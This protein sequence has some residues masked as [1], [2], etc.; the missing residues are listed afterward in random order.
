MSF[1]ELHIGCAKSLT[2]VGFKYDDTGDYDTSG[3]AHIFL[4]ADRRQ[5]LSG[6]ARDLRRY[7]DIAKD[8]LDERYARIEDIKPLAQTVMHELIHAVGG[9]KLP[10]P[11]FSSFRRSLTLSHS[12]Q[13]KQGCIEIG[14]GP[15][16]D[17]YGWLVCNKRRVNGD[18]NIDIADY[19]TVLG[20]A[21]YL[22]Q[23]LG[24]DTFWATGEVD[25]KTLRPQCLDL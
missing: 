1:L 14:D 4:A 17:T 6:T 25:L 8:D 20:Q 11:Y 2:Y 5:P 9:C 16:K 12:D 18:S 22:S 13:S 23:I 21:T 7:T 19:I 15:N 3:L 10:S 24:K